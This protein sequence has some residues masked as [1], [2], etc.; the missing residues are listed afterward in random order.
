[1][2]I[3]SRYNTRVSVQRP[4]NTPDAVGQRVPSWAT[5]VQRWARLIQRDGREAEG[6]AILSITTWELRIRYESALAAITPEWRI[7]TSMQTFDIDSV[8]NK[9]N[10]N[11]ELVL[12]LI[13][14]R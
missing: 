7:T 1:M 6:S 8:I 2:T 12:K 11:R 4:T 5:V 3:S 9:D 14:V 10:A 13:E